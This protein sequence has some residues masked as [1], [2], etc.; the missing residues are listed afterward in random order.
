M[1]QS[2]PTLCQFVLLCYQVVCTW[3]IHSSRVFC[4]S[5][6]LII[7]P[8][9]VFTR[10]ARNIFCCSWYMY[11]VL[12]YSM[13]QSTSWEAKLFSA[14]QEIPRILWNPKVYNRI[15]KYPPPVPILSRLKFFIFYAE[16]Y[17]T[18][19]LRHKRQYLSQI[20]KGS[21]KF[22]LLLWCACNS[23]YNVT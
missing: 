23:H 19:I 21:S 14:S 3:D 10:R 12:T 2:E 22:L 11:Y 7:K 6:R 18:D 8:K 17:S 20:W 4:L 13:E 9:W 5:R 16:I 15:H 1:P